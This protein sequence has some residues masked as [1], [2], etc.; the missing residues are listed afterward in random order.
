MRQP[1]PHRDREATVSSQTVRLVITA[2]DLGIDPR[3]DDGIFA[4]HAAG[5]ITQASLMVGGPSAREAAHRAREAGLTLGLHLDLSEMPPLA[6]RERIPTLLDG[7]GEKLGKHGLRLAL[8]RGSVELAHVILEAEAQLDTF[9]ALTGQCVR[10]VDGHQHIH[11]VPEVAEVLAPVFERRGVRSTRAP[12][13]AAARVADSD[14]SRVYEKMCR[15][16]AQAR[17]TYARVGVRS[18]HGFIGLDLAGGASDPSRLRERVTTHAFGHFGRARVSC[19]L[20]GRRRRRLQPFGGSRA[21]AASPL[22]ASLRAPGRPGCRGARQLRRAVPWRRVVLTQPALPEKLGRDAV[23]RLAAHARIDAKTTAALLALLPRI[24]AHPVLEGAAIT[25]S[26]RLVDGSMGPALSE[27][28][29]LLREETLGGE[30]T[31]FYLLV[32]LLEI[33]IAEERHRTRGVN[34]AI[35]RA[36]WADLAAWCHYLRKREGRLGMTLEMLAWSQ[37]ALTGRLFRVG[38]SGPPLLSELNRAIAN[39]NPR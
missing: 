16:A 3:R 18:T 25:A 33:P 12:Q 37:H 27:L 17:A 9:A 11:C 28:A 5:A 13:P 30:V 19:R 14:A 38:I 22:C 26:R 36:T 31:L 32:A 20:R 34:P 29:E 4:A 23:A 24:A 10:H 6:P 35:S 1:L 39:R 21:R 8:A 7:R 15:D 2:D